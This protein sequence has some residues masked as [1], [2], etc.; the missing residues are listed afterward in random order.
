M[1]AEKTILFVNKKCANSVLIKLNQVGTLSETLDAIFT[2][3]NAGYNVIVSHRSGE[4]EDTFISDLAVGVC[5]GQIKCGAPARSERVC[6]YNRLL[7]IE[8]ELGGNGVY[9]SKVL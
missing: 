7:A 9:A 4:T 3:K 8:D 1:V 6:K 5:S 2:A